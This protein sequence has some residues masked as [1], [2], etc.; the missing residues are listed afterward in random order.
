MAKVIN[1]YRKSAIPAVLVFKKSMDKNALKSVV[2]HKIPR[3]YTNL[4]V[5][6]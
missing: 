4:R 2:I 1:F 3:F 6:K 5:I